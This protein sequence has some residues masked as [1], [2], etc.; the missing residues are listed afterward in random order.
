MEQL[1]QKTWLGCCL[2][3]LVLGASW[4]WH[5]AHAAAPP[6]VHTVTIE[7]LRYI[8]SPIE[9][10]KGDSVVWRNKDPFPHSVTTEDHLIDSGE[11][12]DGKSWTYKANRVGEFS[13]MC[14]LH[15]SMKGKLIVREK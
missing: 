8:P 13:Y 6:R 11:I 3:T 4:E 7:S 1:H 10:V 2:V 9:V 5:G 14:T 15:P 12:G